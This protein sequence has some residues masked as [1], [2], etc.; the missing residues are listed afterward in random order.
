MK[1]ELVIFDWDGTLADSTGHIVDCIRYACEVTKEGFPGEDAARNIIGLGMHEAL[2]QLFGDRTPEF[3]DTFRAAYSDHFFRAP[4]SRD[5]LFDGAIDTLQQLKDRGC[6]LAI[7]TGKSRR[8]MDRALEQLGMGEFFIG[9]KCAD[10][11]RS[12]PNPLMLQMLLEEQRVDPGQAVMIGDT[13]YD[14]EM[15]LKIGMPRIGV[16]YGAHD[17]DRLLS[18][19]PESVISSPVELLDILG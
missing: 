16:N 3:I 6:R 7:A 14:M 2:L 8:G 11:T 4:M 5:D 9:V 18:Y 15:A 12:K 19:R 17:A 13:E 10:E 1:Y